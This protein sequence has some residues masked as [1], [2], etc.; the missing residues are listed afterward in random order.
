MKKYIFK[1]VIIIML[2][3]LAALPYCN[4]CFMKKRS[5]HS[6]E[7]AFPRA[8]AVIINDLLQKDLAYWQWLQKNAIPENCPFQENTII[9]ACWP[10][11]T[12]DQ[13]KIIVACHYCLPIVFYFPDFP[14]DHPVNLAI[15]PESFPNRA[16]IPIQVKQFTAKPPNIYDVIIAFVDENYHYQ[17]REYHSHMEIIHTESISKPSG[18]YPQFDYR[19]AREQ[20]TP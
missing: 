6:S 8:I 2:L 19:K 9:V 10:L 13:A 17:I 14:R 16:C 20:E 4:C 11:K 7:Q 15:L 1:T 18:T 12:P 5:T 3:I